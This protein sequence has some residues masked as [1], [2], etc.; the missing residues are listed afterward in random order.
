MKQV[1]ANANR[2]EAIINATV[3]ALPTVLTFTI[4]S[5]PSDPS[6]RIVTLDQPKF[7][8]SKEDLTANESDTKAAAIRA[9]YVDLISAAFSIYQARYEGSRD[10]AEKIVALEI[11]LA[12]I[13]AKDEDRRNVTETL[14]RIA[15]ERLNEVSGVNL[16]AVVKGVLRGEAA[17]QVIIGDMNYFKQLSQVL[18]ENKDAFSKYHKWR[19]IKSYGVILSEKYNDERFKFLKVKSGLE[20]KPDQKEMC[21]DLL[22]RFLPNVIGRAYIDAA[23]FTRDDKNDVQEMIAKLQRSM[24]AII[25]EKQWMDAS[26]KE[27]ALVKLRKMVVNIAYPEWIRD[28]HLLAQSFPLEPLINDSAYRLLHKMLT[29]LTKDRINKLNKEVNIDLEWPMSPALVNAAY[30]PSQNSMTFP[31]AVL[32]GAFY[33]SGRPNYC[34]YGGIGSVI[35]HE[36]THG[37]DDQG[38]QYDAQGKLNNWWSESTRNNFKLLT[39][40]IV[41]QYSDFVDATTG[42]HVNGK[43]TQGENIADN[44]CVRESYDAVFKDE[45]TQHIALP[46]LESF[47]PQQMFFVSYANVWC[48]LIRPD[49]LRQCINIDPHSPSEYRTNV[50]LMNFDKFAIAFKCKEG[51]PMNP[52]NRVR[53]W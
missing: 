24:E 51:S 2:E 43:N 42:L 6:K 35:G 41:K 15:V 27:R 28:D 50:P 11:A 53:V 17:T 9:A 1:T 12:K 20:K 26:D 10:D 39:S 8:V 31:A 30:E 36:I 49:E 14:K 34:N 18:E 40:A 4:D 46:A 19:T 48:S 3:N 21:I 47:T 25:Q 38:S 45:T 16:T 5:D 29:Y 33:Q 13:S 32:R 23:N 37:F 44:G 52:I 22:V 7:T